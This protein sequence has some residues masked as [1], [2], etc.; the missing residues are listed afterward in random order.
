[1]HARDCT[2]RGDSAARIPE[3]FLSERIPFYGSGLGGFF[4][5][6]QFSSFVR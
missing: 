2:V 4:F 6:L 1:M 3:G 5:S